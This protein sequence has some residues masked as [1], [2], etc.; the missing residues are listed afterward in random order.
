M[1][2]VPAVLAVALLTAL[3]GCGGGVTLPAVAPEE[4]EIFMPG[5]FPTE[6]YKVLSRL[7]EDVPLSATDQELVDQARAK[8][9]SLGA[10]ALV[11]QGIRRTTEGGIEL[12]LEQEQRKVLVGLAVYYPSKHPELNK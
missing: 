7:E 4:V 1:K 11:I 2:Y 9:A 10:D 3:A 12:N 6:D 8:A 5:S